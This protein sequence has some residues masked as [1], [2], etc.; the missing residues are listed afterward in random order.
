[1]GADEFLPAF[2]YLLLRSNVPKL[3]SNGEYMQAFHN[4]IQLLSKAGYC[5]A[6]MTIAIEFILSLDS[7]SLL[8]DRVEFDRKYSAAVREL[9]GGFS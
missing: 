7:S 3:V 1:M 9:N 2:I 8:M 6:N 5:L 4:P